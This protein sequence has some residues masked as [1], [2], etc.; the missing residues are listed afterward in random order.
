MLGC[1]IFVPPVLISSS[2]MDPGKQLR[3]FVS[4]SRTPHFLGFC[5]AKLHLATHVADSTTDI[6]I[7]WLY[8][9]PQNTPN[10]RRRCGFRL[11]FY[12][13]LT[14]HLSVNHRSSIAAKNFSFLHCFSK[15]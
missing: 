8:D 12:N 11:V 13:N 7:N 14:V 9:A 6:K 5:R 3:Y 15:P 1:A 10:V 4:G 2:Y